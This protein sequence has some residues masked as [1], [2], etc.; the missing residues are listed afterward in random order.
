M[1]NLILFHLLLNT[2]GAEK[3]KNFAKFTKPDNTLITLT[4]TLP[5][6]LSTPFN[7]NFASVCASLLSDCTAT[8]ICFSKS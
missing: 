4:L 3:P 6:P 2:Y 7:V 5:I 1:Q 8:S